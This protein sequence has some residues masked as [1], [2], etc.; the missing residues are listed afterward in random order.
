MLFDDFVALAESKDLKASKIGM[1]NFLDAMQ[2]SFYLDQ[3]TRRNADGGR[4]RQRKKVTT[5][6]N[7]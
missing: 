5:E 4:G 2:I 3:T 1:R 7:K 6:A